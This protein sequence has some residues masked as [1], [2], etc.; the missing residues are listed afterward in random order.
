MSIQ[1][2]EARLRGKARKA[3]DDNVKQ[4]FAAAFALCSHGGALIEL[5]PRN[6]EVIRDA[7]SGE[8]VRV[9]V[10]VNVLMDAVQ[11]HASDHMAAAVEAIAIERFVQRVEKLQADEGDDSEGGVL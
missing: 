2:I 3:S 9:R 5:E 1:S 4:T 10:T 6:V 11:R 7:N 8:V